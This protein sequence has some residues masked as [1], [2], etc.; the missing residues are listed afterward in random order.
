M[1]DELSVGL[2][3]SSEDYY[4]SNESVRETCYMLLITETV[5]VQ[6]NQY[7]ISDNNYDCHIDGLEIEKDGGLIITGSSDIAE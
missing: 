4:V 5:N 1:A 2:L 6:L 3:N 7:S